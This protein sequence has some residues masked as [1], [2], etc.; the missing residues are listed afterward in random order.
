[1]AQIRTEFKRP[2]YGDGRIRVQ[3]SSG[4]L[5]KLI[6]VLQYCATSGQECQF[7]VYPEYTWPHCAA[8]ELLDQLGLHLR[9]NSVCVIPFE[10]ISLHEYKRLLGLFPL[11]EDAQ[12]IE[13]EYISAIGDRQGEWIVNCCFIFFRI[14]GGLT[15]VPQRKLFPA[16]LEEVLER[17]RFLGGGTRFI[18]KGEGCC[19][20]SVLCFDLIA[21]TEKQRVRETLAEQPVNI[22]LVPECNP[23]PLHHAYANAFLE[24]FERPENVD[25]QMVIACANLAQGTILPHLKSPTSFGFSRI[26]GKLG[27]TQKSLQNVHHVVEGVLYS[28]SPDSLRAIAEETKPLP[29]PQLKSAIIRPQESLITIT[30]PA[31]DTGPT[32]DPTAGRLDTEIF[33]NRHDSDRNSWYQI[34][35][36][37]HEPLVRHRLGIPKDYL[38]VSRLLGI[39]SQREQ[40]DR[41]LRCSSTPILILGEGGVGKTVLAAHHLSKFETGMGA[42]IIWIDMES[43]AQEEEDLVDAILLKRGQVAALKGSLEDKWTALAEGMLN[44][45]HILVLDSYERWQ[46][47]KYSI[48]RKLYDLHRWPNRVVITMRRL[49]QGVNHSNAAIVPLS[50]LPL[51]SACELIELTTGRKIDLEFLKNAANFVICS[52]LGCIWIGSLLKHFS[53]YE[54]MLREEFLVEASKTTAPQSPLERIYQWCI[55]PL[56]KIQKSVLSIL[57]ELPAEVL[58]EDIADILCTNREQ[59]SLAIERLYEANLVMRRED[60]QLGY[61]FNT[62]HPFVRQFWKHSNTADELKTL[63]ALANWGNRVV[64]RFGGDRNWEGYNSLESRWKNVKYILNLQISS[65]QPEEQDRFLQMWRGINYFLWST[66]R[67][68]ERAQLAHQAGEIADSRDDIKVQCHALCSESE[69][70]WH[71]RSIRDE[72][73]PLLKKA[74]E[75]AD[76]PNHYAEALYYHARML[77]HLGATSEQMPA[78]RLALDASSKAD[79]HARG[80]AFNNLGNV[81]RMQDELKSAVEQYNQ[82]LPYFE[83]T[84]DRE[85]IAVI[86]RNLGRVSLDEGRYVEALGELEQAMSTFRELRLLIEDAETAIYHARALA[87]VHEMDDAILELANIE[88][89]FRSIGSLPRLQEVLEAR[90]WISG[91]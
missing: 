79:A 16:E 43:I 33:V 31:I 41:E 55:K 9:R 27:R 32:K 29:I 6:G 28:D 69:A 73:E 34:H 70:M 83:N 5:K 77:R 21:R 87:G 47:K 71:L 18:M 60:A 3:S 8:H 7:I 38:H 76:D 22:V 37:L 1:M 63:K 26:V 11:Q 19:F 15:A 68:R 84:Q 67:W 53:D 66:G 72:A 80:L 50:P 48:P 17:Q 59:I 39:D 36:S 49:P 46:L 91:L 24:L 61:S 44:N 45:V 82:A 23:Q 81:F 52:P 88:Q 10:H 89:T 51:E 13:Y 25:R 90:K 85:M 42:H 4:Y 54:A 58:E 57:C 35:G 20:S 65:S 30:P 78:A 14:D 74:I 75:I 62:R 12:T 64:K 86:H 56:N 40:L 2:L